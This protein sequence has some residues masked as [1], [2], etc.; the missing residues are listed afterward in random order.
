MNPDTLEFLAG[1]NEWFNNPSPTGGAVNV[2]KLT[3]GKYAII[4]SEDFE[5]INKHKWYTF[6]DNWN[7]YAVRNIRKVNGKRTMQRMHRVIMNCPEGLEI[8]HRNH[9]TLDNRKCNLRICTHAQNHYNKKSQKGISKFKGVSWHK[10]HKK[11][12]AYIGLNNK[13]IYL[14]LFINEIDAA[15]AYDKKAKELFGDF[16]Y[17]NFNKEE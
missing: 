2:I 16:A 17:L 14:G 9:D 7:W 3:Q 4:D 5:R 15:K 13:D 12:A 10:R 6:Y 11:W 8:D 1:Y